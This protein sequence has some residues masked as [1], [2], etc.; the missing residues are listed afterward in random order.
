MTVCGGH[1]ICPWIYRYAA[2]KE[3]RIGEKE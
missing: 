3:T 1:A 2:V